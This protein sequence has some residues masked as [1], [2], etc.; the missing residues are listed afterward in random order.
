METAVEP[1]VGERNIAGV[2]SKASA[3]VGWGGWNGSRGAT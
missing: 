2:S 3:V 1:D